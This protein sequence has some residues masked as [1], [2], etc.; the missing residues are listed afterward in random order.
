MNNWFYVICLLTAYGSAAFQDNTLERLTKAVPYYYQY[1][2]QH[3]GPR[4]CN[5]TSVAMVLDHFNV[6]K[7][8]K[9]NL[10]TPDY[11]YQRFGIKQQPEQLADIFNTVAKENNVQVRDTLYTS[12]TIDQLRNHV[13]KGLPA[14][15]HG[16]F[17][18]AGHILVVTGFDGKHYTVNDPAGRWNLKKF[19]EG[20]YDTSQSG[21]QI[22]YPATEFEFAI[23]DNGT[24]DDLWLHLFSK[25]S[26]DITT[27]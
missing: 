6:L 25:V 19:G 13:M 2:N 3:E 27:K 5:I 18:E 17:T 15:V 10:R 14:I 21:Q 24:G 11:L 22:L 4:A 16:W 8:I 23:N 9:P 7:D 12:G 1:D 26:A 20:K